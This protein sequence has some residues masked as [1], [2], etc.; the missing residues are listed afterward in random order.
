MLQVRKLWTLV[1]HVG[2]Y[3]YDGG[4]SYQPER[5][6]CTVT[7]YMPGNLFLVSLLGLTLRGTM[8]FVT[9]LRAGSF[10]DHR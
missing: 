4:A 6:L 5:N 7:N 3:P 9:C 8:L 2:A 1:P 10:L